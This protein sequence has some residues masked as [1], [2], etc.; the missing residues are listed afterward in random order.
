[1]DSKVDVCWGIGYADLRRAPHY[2]LMMKEVIVSSGFASMSL[3]RNH[4]SGT[5]VKDEDGILLN[6]SAVCDNRAPMLDVNQQTIHERQS[7]RVNKLCFAS[8]SQSW[9]LPD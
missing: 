2:A 5:L 8:G 1:L 6:H 4:M 7:D 3:S 9:K